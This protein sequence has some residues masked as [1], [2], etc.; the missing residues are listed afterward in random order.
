MVFIV[1]C[2][3]RSTP[4]SGS[5]GAEVARGI[6]ASCGPGPR[7]SRFLIGPVLTDATE[8]HAA[9]GPSVGARSALPEVL[10]E[11]GVGPDVWAED[12]H[13]EAVV[14]GLE[15]ARDARAHAHGIERLEIDQVVVE[16]H[17]P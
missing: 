6:E 16:L 7:A 3:L 1:S 12:Q 8:R 2:F 11:L 15:G 13:F 17:A 10:D 9:S 14:V 4:V 5:L